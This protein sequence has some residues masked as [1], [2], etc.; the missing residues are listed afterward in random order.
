MLILVF[1]SNVW[2]PLKPLD[3]IPEKFAR[4]ITPMKFEWV[5]GYRKP[6]A[7]VYPERY[8]KK[9]GVWKSGP[10]RTAQYPDARLIYLT[11]TGERIDAPAHEK[12][13]DVAKRVGALA[14]AEPFLQA[15]IA[16]AD[17]LERH[18][19][20][21]CFHIKPQIVDKKGEVLVEGEMILVPADLILPAILNLSGFAWDT[22]VCNIKLYNDTQMVLH[23]TMLNWLMVIAPRFIC[24][25]MGEPTKFPKL[26]WHSLDEVLRWPTSAFL[27][28]FEILP[29]VSE[30]E[31][32]PSAD[33]VTKKRA[34]SEPEEKAGVVRDSQKKRR[35]A[36]GSGETSKVGGAAKSSPSDDPLSQEVK[37]A[38]FKFVA[39]G[40]SS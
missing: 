17:D 18:D 24:F 4:H 11:K 21:V 33:A 15:Y 3:R 9:L 35:V 14:N 2:A 28:D 29:S 19:R 16:E 10:G 7:G 23:E 12:I 13:E 5:E 22:P 6:E 25:L 39:A 8:E 40:K 20:M 36:A 30:S 32:S 27:V 38:F 34:G 31:A 37:N 26:Q 1:S